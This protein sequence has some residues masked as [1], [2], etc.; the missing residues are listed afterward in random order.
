[1]TGYERRTLTWS[2]DPATL[3]THTARFGGIAVIY[4]V[5]TVVTSTGLLVR[6]PGRRVRFYP[7]T[8]RR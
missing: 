2:G 1:M 5:L 3:S 7:Y 4:P 8:P 6:G